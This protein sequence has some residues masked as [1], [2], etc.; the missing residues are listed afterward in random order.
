MGGQQVLVT[1]ATGRI[2][3]ILRACW[4]EG[5]GRWLAR[6]PRAGFLCADP[7]DAGALARTGQGST[8]QGSTGQ[9]PDGQ[10]V[11][12]LLALAGPIWGDLSA[13]L[14]L[15][16]AAVRAGAALGVPVRLASTA[17]VYG[18]GQGLLREDSPLA[19]LGDY[20]RA[21]AAMEDEALAL[22]GSLGVRASVLRI[23]NVAGADAI[24]G[25]WRPGFA[26][27]RFPDGRTPRR[28]YV[29][30]RT[31][32]RVLD[33]LCAIPDLPPRLN[34]AAPGAV[35]MGAL[36][37]AAGLD[38]Q[39]RPAPEEAIAEVA[40]DVAALERYCPLDPDES[41]PETMVAQW[42]DVRRDLQERDDG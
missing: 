33:R 19:P 30:P 41:R 26:L 25:G 23:G 36:L 5:R 10:G 24:L 16:L 7:A 4:P 11:S 14:P 17:A 31:L 13:T 22:A 2:G 34:I 37:D 12:A 9:D 18:A 39:P 20:G 6:A 21:R 27:D 42:C 40:L 1:G 29:G 38:W 32:A 3:T 8:G 35:E 15:A 28:S